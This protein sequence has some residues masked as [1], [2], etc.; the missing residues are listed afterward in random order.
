MSEVR[1]DFDLL[2][3]GG[4]INGAG[5]ARDAAGRGLKVLLCERDDLASHTSSASTKLIHGGLRYLEL[6]HFD[7]V[8]KSLKEREVLLQSAPHILWPLRFVMPHDS[9]LRPAWLIRAGLLLYDNLAQRRLLP[10]SGS[11]DLRTHPAGAPLQ[12]RYR[13]GFVYSDGWADDARLVVLN[14]LDAAERGATILTRTSCERIERTDDLW[15]AQLRDA[16]IG[17]QAGGAAADGLRTVTARAVVNAAGPWVGELL[18]ER[19]PVRSTRTVRLVKGSHIVVPQL[20]EHRFAYIFQTEDRRIVFAIPY[21][22]RFTLIGTTDVEYDGDPAYPKIDADEKAYLCA[23]ANRYFERSIAPADVLWSYS[24][25]RPLLDDESADARSVTRDYALDLDERGA[26]LLS[27]FGGKLTTYRKL[28]EEAVDRLAPKLGARSGRWTAGATLPGGDIPGGHFEPYL[29]ALERK[30]PWVPAELR[31]RYAR[32]YG[33][34]IDRLLA[35]CRSMTD[36]GE[37]VLPDLHA[38]EIE[39]LRKHEWARSAADILWRRSKLGLH[40]PANAERTLDAWLVQRA[41]TGAANVAHPV[42]ARGA[43]G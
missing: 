33:T 18:H 6:Y 30:Y 27:V 11:I 31:R 20:F 22:Q 19:S 17:A 29:R 40:L 39:Y 35:D 12:R 2:V 9:H 23:L 7:L 3:V 25:V 16:T 8:R 5:I 32:A 14:A 36:L 10:G 42:D 38:R 21:E 13:R 37:T 43:G 28:A 26:P 24:G 15:R 1:A 4:G 34:R 41:R